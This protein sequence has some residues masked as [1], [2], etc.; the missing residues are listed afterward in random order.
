[1]VFGHGV[2]ERERCLRSQNCIP[3][4]TTVYEN[5]YIGERRQMEVRKE[6]V[7][8]ACRAA[9]THEFARDLPEGDV[10]ESGAALSRGQRQRLEISGTRLKNLNVILGVCASPLL[11]SH[12]H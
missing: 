8:E 11:P 4:D 10:G 6:E 2:G 3:F 1:M 9:L 12:G 7:E 5:A